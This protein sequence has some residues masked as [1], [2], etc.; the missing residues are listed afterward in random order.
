[1]RRAARR[2]CLS[3]ENTP[4]PL[5]PEVDGCATAVE[6]FC[7]HKGVIHRDGRFDFPLAPLSHLAQNS[8]LRFRFRLACGK[9]E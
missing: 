7:I 5:A 4:G 8:A 6:P 3:G 2:R 1:M 9:L